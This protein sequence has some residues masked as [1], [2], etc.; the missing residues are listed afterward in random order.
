M[1][2]LLDFSTPIR[3]IATCQFFQKLMLTYCGLNQKK[4][5]SMNRKQ[6]IN[7]ASLIVSRLNVHLLRRI[8]MDEVT[9]GENL[10]MEFWA[11]E[12][13]GKGEQYLREQA[14]YFPTERR[15]A[16]AEY[17][18]VQGILAMKMVHRGEKIFTA[19]PSRIPD[20]LKAEAQVV[21][22]ELD[23]LKAAFEGSAEVHRNTILA[24]IA[25][26]IELYHQYAD[27]IVG[28]HPEWQKDETFSDFLKSKA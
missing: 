3:I 6:K 26:E 10:Y 27:L 11:A 21:L 17:Y 9:N 14:T 25:E 18:K 23:F 5:T 12:Q 22:E 20:Y 7:L 8:F 13:E 24:T 2:G 15:N 1:R 19:F 28:L 4:Q 16:L